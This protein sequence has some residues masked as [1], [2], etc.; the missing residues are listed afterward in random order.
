MGDGRRA[1]VIVVV[2]IAVRVYND[3]FSF[4]TVFVTIRENKKNTYRLGGAMPPSPSLPPWAL[5][6]VGDGGRATGEG[7]AGGVV[8]RPH[9]RTVGA[10]CAARST[11]TLGAGWGGGR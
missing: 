5:G 6:L 8:T 2:V 4:S 10:G 9:P 1:G 3:N 11:A 7:V